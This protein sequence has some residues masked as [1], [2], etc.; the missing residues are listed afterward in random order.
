MKERTTQ[1]ITNG[2]KQ[3]KKY[4]TPKE[5][6]TEGASIHWES[7]LKWEKQKFL[8]R[9]LEIFRAAID[10]TKKDLEIFSHAVDEIKKELEEL[11][12]E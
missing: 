11:D 5:Q 12:N 1:N 9:K 8:I 3:M 10:E 7:M 4:N 2:E 6:P